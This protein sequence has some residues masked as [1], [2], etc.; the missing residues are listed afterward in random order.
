MESAGE[1]IA[2]GLPRPEQPH[3]QMPRPIGEEVLHLEIR[4]HGQRLAI[5][6]C[7]K[8]TVNIPSTAITP[9]KPFDLFKF[10][11]RFWFRFREW[12]TMITVCNG[13]EPLRQVPRQK[14]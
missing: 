10:C 8:A 1:E 13:N 6:R 5:A 11:F 12:Q 4:G 3:A 2:E 9:P 7:G 14:P